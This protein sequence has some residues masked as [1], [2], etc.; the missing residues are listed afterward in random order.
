MNGGVLQNGWFIMESPLKINDS[1]RYPYSRKP[2]CWSLDICGSF[3]KRG[4]PQI[5]HFDGI[6]MTNHPFWGAPLKRLKGAIN[7]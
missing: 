1:G 6:S 7:S 4:Y 5:I 3:L 2:P